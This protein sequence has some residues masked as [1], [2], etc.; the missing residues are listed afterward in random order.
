MQTKPAL[1]ETDLHVGVDGCAGGWFAIARRG[2]EPMAMAL[3]PGFAAV[4]DHFVNATRL[5]VDMPIGLSSRQPRHCDTA[6]RAH[7]PLGR[8]SSVF[9]VPV[10]DA[11]YAPDYATACE[12]NF[13]WTAKRLSRQSWNICTKIREVDALLRQRAELADRVLESHP[14]L[15]FAKLAGGHDA[16]AGK[17]TP[18]GR[19]QRLGLLCQRWPEAESVYESALSAYRRR[20]LARDDILD[21]MVLA[22]VASVSLRGV[23]DR[24][25]RDA[26]ALPMQIWFPASAG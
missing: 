21:A 9:P 25:E 1:T 22:T 19:Q 24:G 4:L 10:R 17:K 5:L 14:E 7:L 18:H 6:A 12:C 16:L 23:S 20:Q 13:T 2:D 3:F 15:C 26:F 11:V 8:R